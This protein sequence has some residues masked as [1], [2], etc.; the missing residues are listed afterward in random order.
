MTLSGTDDERKVKAREIR[1]KIKR[2]VLAFL[3][4]L[5]IDAEIA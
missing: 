3:S 5:G 2:E 1:D 4:R